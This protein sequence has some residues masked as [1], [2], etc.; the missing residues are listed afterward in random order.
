MKIHPNMYNYS[1]YDNFKLPT[2]TDDS[3]KVSFEYNDKIK[4]V[5]L[6]M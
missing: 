4:E 2:I 5:W 3:Q 6:K 1:L